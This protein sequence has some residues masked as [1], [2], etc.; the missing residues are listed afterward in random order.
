[1]KGIHGFDED[2]D[3]YEDDEP[4]DKIITAFEQGEKFVTARPLTF[5]IAGPMQPAPSS[6][7]WPLRISVAAAPVATIVLAVA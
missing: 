4:L 5:E 1:M 6:W 3:F 2:E 7:R